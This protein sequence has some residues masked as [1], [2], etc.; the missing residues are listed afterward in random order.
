[1]GFELVPPAFVVGGPGRQVRLL[2]KAAGYGH[3]ANPRELSGTNRASNGHELGTPEG[4]N[5]ATHG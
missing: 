3:R 2:I 5:L 4:V 1:M